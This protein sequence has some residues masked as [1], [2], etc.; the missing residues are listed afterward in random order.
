[1]LFPLATTALHCV[2]ELGSTWLTMLGRSCCWADHACAGCCWCRLLEDFDP[3][4]KQRKPSCL[5]RSPDR[6]LPKSLDE[7]P[8]LLAIINDELRWGW[9]HML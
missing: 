1:L 4:A 8:H 7:D 5:T 6:A 9:W 3:A 2:S